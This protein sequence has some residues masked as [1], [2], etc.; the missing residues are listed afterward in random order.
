[1]R[2]QRYYII[3][4]FLLL[5]LLSSCSIIKKSDC[6]CPEFSIREGTKNYNNI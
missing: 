4:F 5:L 1:M 6:D 3:T 2:L